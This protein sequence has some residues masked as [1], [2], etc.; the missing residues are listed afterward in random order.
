L[1]WTTTRHSR[2][3]GGSRGPFNRPPSRWSVAGG[4]WSS[5]GRSIGRSGGRVVL[6]VVVVVAAAVSCAL[7]LYARRRADPTRS[8]RSLRCEPW[9]V[10][11]LFFFLCVFRSESFVQ[12]FRGVAGRGALGLSPVLVFFSYRACACACVRAR[13]HSRRLSFVVRRR[14]R[15]RRYSAPFFLHCVGLLSLHPLAPTVRS[16]ARPSPVR[17]RA[18]VP[19]YMRSPSSP[20]AV[21][22]RLLVGSCLVA[23]APP[24]VPPFLPACLPTSGL[25][26]GRSVR[27][28]TVWS[29][30]SDLCCQRRRRR[31]W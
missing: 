22:R 2:C 6:F 12:S 20:A 28:G 17:A 25:A 31:S 9:P 27:F 7:Q 19:P 15:R 21:V 16:P 29:R 18:R 1:S 4:R 26:V 14:R 24:K 8:A 11:S 10:P 23:S 5:W 3:R 30:P 13:R